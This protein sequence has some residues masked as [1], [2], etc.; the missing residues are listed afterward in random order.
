MFGVFFFQYL[1]K[2]YKDFFFFKLPRNKRVS[3][4][5][6]CFFLCSCISIAFCML[7]IARHSVGKRD[8]WCGQPKADPGPV[9]IPKDHRASIVT[10][11]RYFSKST[12]LGSNS[13]DL[14]SLTPSPENCILSSSKASLKRNILHFT[15]KVLSFDKLKNHLQPFPSCMSQHRDVRKGEEKAKTHGKVQI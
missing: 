11:K 9:Q 15:Y 13:I 6:T 4:P 3:S 2:I 1:K 5:F 12:E 14:Y 7:W 8:W 10:G